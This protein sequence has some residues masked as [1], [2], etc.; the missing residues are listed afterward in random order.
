MNETTL[1]REF[2]LEMLEYIP[3]SGQLLQKKKR[4]KIKVGSVAG[5]ITPTGYRY[6]QL[7]DRKFAAHR[8]IW[9]IEYNKFPEKQID[10]IDGNGLNN[11][12]DNLREATT[13]QN[14]ENKTAQQNNQL[15]VRGVCFNKRLGK[16]IA[17][18]QHNGKNKHIGVFA[19]IQEAR[20]AYTRTANELFTHYNPSRQHSK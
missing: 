19:T 10:H 17:Q 4:P 20:E 5:V 15:G 9:L 13:K 6:I 18:I 11:R 2:V 8:L 3:E 7:Q 1:T 16:F 12:I 14:S